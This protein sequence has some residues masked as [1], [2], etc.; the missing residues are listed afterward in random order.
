MAMWLV[1]FWVELNSP[2][3]AYGWDIFLFESFRGKGLA[4]AVM[5][6]IQ[7]LLKMRGIEKYSICVFEGNTIA[8]NLYDRLGFRAARFDEKSRQYSLEIT[9]ERS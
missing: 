7:R 1:F 3:S 6:E 4:K 9:F 8:R 5:L 2:T